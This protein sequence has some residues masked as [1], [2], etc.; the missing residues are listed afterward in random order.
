MYFIIV[1][2]AVVFP[3]S[4]STV[5][6]IYKRSLSFKLVIFHEVTKTQEIYYCTANILTC[7]IIIQIFVE[8]SHTSSTDDTILNWF[9]MK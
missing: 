7:F 5:Y 9:W 4:V 6:F 1:C 8:I 3:K 2:K